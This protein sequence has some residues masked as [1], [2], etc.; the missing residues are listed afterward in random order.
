[1]RNIMNGKGWVYSGLLVVIL[2]LTGFGIWFV[3][4]PEDK[5][6]IPE[7][8]PLVLM[9]INNPEAGTLSQLSVYED[10]TVIHVED[11]Y[12][13]MPIPQGEEF[14]RTWRTGRV[15]TGDIDYFFSYLDSIDY[16]EIEYAFIRPGVIEETIPPEKLMPNQKPKSRGPSFYPGGPDDY[17]R[18]YANDGQRENT[19]EVLCYISTDVDPYNE[20]PSPAKYI[21]EELADIIEN[22]TEEVLVVEL[23]K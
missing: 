22:N 1:M 19:I 18:I 21:Y 5:I 8:D 9:D 10:G 2:A 13:E 15:S 14:T 17:I 6:E 4:N 16:Y 11:S 23:T 12:P 7:G 20:L 3:L